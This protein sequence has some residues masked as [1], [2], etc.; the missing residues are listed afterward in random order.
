MNYFKLK[1]ALIIIVICTTI[2]SFLNFKNKKISYN[3]EIRPIFNKKCIVCHGGVKKLGGFSLLFPEEAYS[4]AKSGKF[5]IIPFD[6]KN[7]ELI[8]RLKTH[9]LEARMP[10]N[11]EPLTDDEI[12]KIE[13]WID[14]G[15]KWE[16]HW[17]YIKPDFNISLPEIGERWAVNG[18]D[19]FVFKKLEKENLTPSNEADRT[20]LLRRLSLD[21][22]GLPPNPQETAAFLKDSSPNA[23]EKQVDKLLKSSQFGERWASMWL[24]LARYADSKGYEKDLDRSIWKYRDWVIRAFN[25]DMPFDQFTVEQLAGDLLPNAPNESLEKLENRLI[26]TAFHRNTMSNDEGGTNDE[27]FR[28][29]ALLDR[30]AT[31]MEVWQGTTM[32]CVQ[33][34]SHPYDPFHHEEFYQLAA[35]F[36]NSQDRDLYND[37]PPKIMSKK[38]RNF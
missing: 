7:S 4:K 19:N 6:A 2:F 31:T 22:I 24:D 29:M 35:F 25:N 13:K 17:A 27:E 23:Y 12:N 8:K 28:N 38:F 16:N 9:D 14:Q 33:C 10:K 18:I 20:T 1:S 5:A 32:A 11:K 26:A 34:H 3:E 30:V 36:N 37:K 21:L 15:A